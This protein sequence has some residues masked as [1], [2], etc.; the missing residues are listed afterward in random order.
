MRFSFAYGDCS[1]NDP[2]E[3][4]SII[5]ADS[6]L[7]HESIDHQQSFVI[8]NAE[9]IELLIRFDN[10]DETSFSICA[11][12]GQEDLIQSRSDTENHSGHVKSKKR[13]LA[14]T[15]S[16]S[17]KGINIDQTKQKKDDGFRDTI[18]RIKLNVP[19][20]D[21]GALNDSQ[22]AVSRFRPLVWVGR[23]TF[24]INGRVDFH[25]GSSENPTMGT[26]EDWYLIN[27][28]PFG[29]PIHVHLINFQV[30]REY[31]LLVTGNGCS[32][33]ELDFLLDAL[34]ITPTN[35]NT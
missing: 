8:H 23:Q 30:V 7:F 14:D 1:P 20:T 26:V 4:F 11:E 27:T 16:Y 29:H 18:D 24:T 10:P 17:I 25:N 28:I 33:Y 21:L 35:A 34:A 2:R 13:L 3:F 32:V 15:R 9:R 5:G 22:I 6:S 31:D 12:E 19:Y